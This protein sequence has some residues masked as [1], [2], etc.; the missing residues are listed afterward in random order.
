MSLPRV[1]PELGKTLL[2]YLPAALL[3]PAV[4]APPLNHDVAAI[5]DF[6]QRWIGGEA[7]YSRLLIPD[8]PLIFVLNLLPAYV[9]KHTGLDAILALQLCVLFYG[10]VVWWLTVRLRRHGEEGPIERYFLDVA[11]VLV[12]VGAGYD[13]GQREHLM[14]LGALPYLFL[15][16]RRAQG[17][18]D[19]YRYIV[20]ILAAVA[21][22][23]KPCFI[24]IPALVEL[25]LLFTLGWRSYVRDPVPWAMVVVWTIYLAS[26]P[27]FFPDYLDVMLTLIFNYYVGGSTVWQTILVPRMGIALALLVP[28]LWVGYRGNN[29]LVKILS[30]AAV[31]A[32]V[33]ALVQ[34]KGWSYHVVPIE[35]FGGVLAGTIAT[36]WLICMLLTSANIPRR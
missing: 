20:A 3:F 14:V 2:A 25:Y 5:L 31:G 22:A 11:P 29:V 34:R 27:V 15:A 7:L 10:A 30:L 32:A 17:A 4:L 36:H 21:S 24:G 18:R 6:T 12:L 1:R 35:L 13:F 28:L 26:L 33:S 23:I 9:G 19:S 8:P 16:T